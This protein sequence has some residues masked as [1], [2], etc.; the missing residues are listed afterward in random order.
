[1]IRFGM[2]N[3]MIT[4][5]GKYWEYGGSDVDKK[6]LMIGGFDPAVLVDFVAA[7]ILEN[8]RDLFEDLIYSKVY[9]D[10][11]SKLI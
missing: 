1:M 7:F 2:A 10:A 3:T 4:F 9:C 11:G 6:G 5:N 8:S